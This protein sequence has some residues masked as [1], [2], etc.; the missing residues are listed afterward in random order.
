[1]PQIDHFETKN[2]M[3]FDFFEHLKVIEFPVKRTS[4]TLQFHLIIINVVEDLHVGLLEDAVAAA[5][6]NFM[7]VEAFNEVVQILG[8]AVEGHLVVVVIIKTL[9]E[10]E[11][12]YEMLNAITFTIPMP[13]LV[14]KI[15]LVVKINQLMV[16]QMVI[17][18]AVVIAKSSIEKQTRRSHLFYLESSNRKMLRHKLEMRKMNI[19]NY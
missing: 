3:V 16:K 19:R 7:V 4:S 14:V 9:V 2:L 12:I 5:V 8:V 17:I 15:S 10:V 13:I 11:A 18:M 1:M 6:V